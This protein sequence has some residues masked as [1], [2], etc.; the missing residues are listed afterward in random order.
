MT[1]FRRFLLPLLLAAPPALSQLP[2]GITPEMVA[3]F[4][5]MRPAEQQVIASQFGISLNQLQE[6]IAGIALQST[7]I[8]EVQTIQPP[9]KLSSEDRT[10]TAYEDQNEEVVVAN[11]D[12]FMQ[13]LP[14]FGADIFDAEISTFVPVDNAPIPTDYML[15]P[16]D[17]LAVQLYGNQN[18]SLNLTVDREGVVNF[19][20]LGP[21]SVAGLSF[22]GAQELLLN[23]VSEEM[24]GVR[25]AISL[26]R[27]R[28]INIFLAG[29][30][31][32]P[33]TYAVS[34]LTTVTQAL[35][36]SG[37]ISDIGSLRNI[38]IRRNNQTVGTFDLYDLL[39]RGDA[40]SDLRLQSGDVVFIPTVGPVAQIDGAVR[41]PAAFELANGETLADLIAMAGGFRSNAY[42][43]DVLRRSYL[44]GG[45]QQ[46]RSLNLHETSAASILLSDGDGFLVSD[47]SSYIKNRIT[48]HGAVTRPGPR[49]WEVGMRISDVFNSV[50]E[51]LNASTVDLNYSLIVRIKNTDRQIE[52]V[53]FNLGEAIKNPGSLADP[54]LQAEDELLV[55]DLPD[56]MRSMEIEQDREL[57]LLDLLELE[58]TQVE[59]GSSRTELLAPLIEKLRLQAD[60]EESV[61]LVN[62]L[63]NVKVPG[64]YPLTSNMTVSQLISAAGGLQD[65]AVDQAE[66]LRLSEQD[67]NIL[68]VEKIELDLNTSVPNRSDLDFVLLS[69]D[70]LLIRTISDWNLEEQVTITGEVRFPGAYTIVPGDTIGDLLRR[71]GG[72]KDDAFIEGAVFTRD[73][74]KEREAEQARQFARLIRDNFAA[75][76]MTQE[77]INTS[78]SEINE[79]ASYFEDYEGSGRMVVDLDGIIAGDRSIDIELL[80]GDAL[81]LPRRTEA[82]TVVGAVFHEGSH[83]YSPTLTVEGYLELSGGLVQR[84]QFRDVYV[85]KADGSVFIPSRERSLLRFPATDTLLGPGDTIVAPVDTA[86]KDRWAV[87]KDIT[88]IAYQAGV[89]L[90]SIMA[91][92]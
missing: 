72:L 38:Q 7:G 36:V 42:I 44:V 67:G 22:S 70:T 17:A 51:D 26:G 6:R 56:V 39:M 92:F 74:L 15:G 71:A 19:P 50:T 12:S 47:S 30:A 65:S 40:S 11:A 49:G 76:S 5:Q 46:L 21:I 88:Q 66:L 83:R 78:F 85:L 27:L 82:V 20:D 64:T 35:F 62:V 37:G 18:Q 29:E 32:N 89:S 79:I 81:H 77:L 24:I 60:R 3:Q 87:I 57:S 10:Q 25:A 28:A 90:A 55:F 84:A 8:G 68:E 33:G 2:A 80:S 61:R 13:P 23:R 34:A 9:T 1:R 48:V 31:A 59:T 45:T 4:Q 91:A 69:R 41:R 14:L 73:V 53:Q 52:V 63:G 16:G 58:A 54:E 75:R 43:S 86:Y